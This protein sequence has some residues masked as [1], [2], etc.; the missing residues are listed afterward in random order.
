[1]ETNLKSQEDNNKIFGS[2]LISTEESRVH[3][4][5]LFS[6]LLCKHIELILY[7]LMASTDSI[8]I[9]EDITKSKNSNFPT[10]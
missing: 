6:I 2:T 10:L 7:W 4:R 9:S 3:T 5:K 8:Q 1:M